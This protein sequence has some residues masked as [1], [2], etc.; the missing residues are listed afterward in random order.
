MAMG[1]LGSLVLPNTGNNLIATISQKCYGAEID[2][3]VLNPTGA[4][5]TAEIA[6]SPNAAS[7]PNADDYIEKGGVCAASGGKIEHTD[8]IV[9]AGAKI[10]VKG[11][12]A[13]L[14]VRVSGKT[15]TNL[16]KN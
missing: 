7:A 13:G 14:I 11:S 4:D 1:L 3:E 12:A 6:I 16:K 5:I 2:I 8:K 15:V 10:F 9:D